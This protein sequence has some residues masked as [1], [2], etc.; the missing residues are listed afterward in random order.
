MCVEGEVW[1]LQTQSFPRRG[2]NGGLCPMI[3][4]EE[5]QNSPSYEVSGLHIP[6]SK[7]PE[8]L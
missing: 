4:T 3:T 5:R 2:Q 7:L 6:E 1:L 8:E